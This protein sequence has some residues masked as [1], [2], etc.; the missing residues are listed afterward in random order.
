MKISKKTSAV[1]G[2]AAGRPSKIRPSADRTY[3]SRLTPRGQT[4]IPQALREAL[5][6]HAG[7]ILRYEISGG[8]LIAEKLAT[9]PAEDPFKFFTEWASPADDAAFAY[10]SD[11]VQRR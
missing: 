11:V 10:L 1:K 2:G 6:L 4:V 9:A 7:D 3:T 8:K 5:N